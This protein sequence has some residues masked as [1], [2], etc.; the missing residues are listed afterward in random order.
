[1]SSTRRFV[2]RL[3]ALVAG[4]TLCITGTKSPAQVD[5]NA[6]RFEGHTC[7]VTNVVFNPDGK[8]LLVQSGDGVT[9]HEATTGKRL[10]RMEVPRSAHGTSVFSPDGKFVAGVVD[11]HSMRWRALWRVVSY[12]FGCRVSCDTDGRRL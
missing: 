6:L 8:R 3:L 9:I 10:A 11:F 2:E 7:S 4:F 5:D 12:S 1:M